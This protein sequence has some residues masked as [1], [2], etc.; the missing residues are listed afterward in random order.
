MDVRLSR[1]VL[2]CDCPLRVARNASRMTNVSYDDSV[3]FSER[4]G[5]VMSDWTG[6]VGRVA[7][8]LREQVL[9]LLRNAILN[10]ELKPGERLVER[11]LIE[12]IGV[13]RTT[14]REVLRELASEGLVSVIPQKGAIVAELPAE[15]AADLYEVRAALEAVIV[16]RFVERASDEQVARLR[17]AADEYAE[18]GVDGGDIKEMLAAKDRFYAVLIEGAGSAAMQQIH[19]GIQARVRVLRAKSLSVPGRPGQAAKEISALA[20]AIGKRDSAAAAE[21]SATHIR[22]AASSQKSVNEAATALA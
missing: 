19:S 7:A 6:R 15:D 9:N 11:E 2:G 12:R 4:R 17:E 5:D 8:P 10:F 18:V 21:L 14:I 3:S 20:D 16:Q 13:S 22:A 1:T